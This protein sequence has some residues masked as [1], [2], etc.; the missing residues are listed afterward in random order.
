MNYNLDPSPFVCGQE[1]AVGL[2]TF[3]LFNKIEKDK[4][5]LKLEGR[6]REEAFYNEQLQDQMDFLGLGEYEVR[7]L[8]KIFRL[9]DTNGGGLI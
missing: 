6:I 1:E 4:A 5:Q 8:H 9:M 7:E 3:V 2:K